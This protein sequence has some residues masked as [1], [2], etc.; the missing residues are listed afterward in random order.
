M[1]LPIGFEKSGNKMFEEV[2]IPPCNPAPAGIGKT[3]VPISQ[4]DD[5]SG[6]LI[7]ILTSLCVSSKAMAKCIA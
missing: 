1:L 3:L 2:N 6:W 5:V 4:L 7:Q